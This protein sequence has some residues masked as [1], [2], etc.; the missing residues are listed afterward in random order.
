MLIAMAVAAAG[1]V[2]ATAESTQ[3]AALPQTAQA[4]ASGQLPLVG[5]W[6]LDTTRIPAEERPR[7]VTLDFRLSGDQK[8]TGRSEIVAADGSSWHAEA[9]GA[10]DGVPVP[11]IVAG[12]M[13]FPDMVSMRQPAPNTLVLTFTKEGAP[14]STR[15]YT[16]EED[17]KSMKETIVWA[18]DVAPRMVTT[19]FN[20][21]D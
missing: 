7:S 19:Y 20:R 1:I 9:T 21:A 18:G 16:V 3:Q 2:I 15:V 17:S 11:V 8:W 5:R 4:A 14:V 13:A 12:N 10:A 6:S